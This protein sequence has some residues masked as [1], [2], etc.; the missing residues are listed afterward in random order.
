[1]RRSRFAGAGGRT[2]GNDP[3]NH[4]ARCLL[5]PRSEFWSFVCERVLAPQSDHSRSI[6]EARMPPT[7]S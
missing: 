4:R 6:L 7:F 2:S 5:A 3:E 1:M